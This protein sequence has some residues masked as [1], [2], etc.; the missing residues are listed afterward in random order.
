MDDV[1]IAVIGAGIAGLACARELA[2]ADVAVTVFEKARGL[3]GRLATR[4]EANLVFDHGA[5]YLTAR[6]RAFSRFVEAATHTG[7]VAAWKPRIREDD[8]QW[9]APIGDWYVGR[10]GMSAAVRPLARHVEV[11][12]S[13]GVHELL[14]GQRGWEL[15]TDAGTAPR[16]F[17]AVAV[18]VP[19]PQALTL[20][21]PLGRTFQR[22]SEVRMA[23]CWTVM[24][25]FDEPVDAGAEV[26][27][28]TSGSLTWAAC[29]SSKP[30]RPDGPQCWVAHATPAWSREHLEDDAGDVAQSLWRE[31][32]AA[33]GG[34]L[35]APATLRAHRWRHAFVEQPLGSPCLVDE[36]SAVGACGDW[37]VA[38]RVEAAFDSGRSLAHA[39]LSIVGRASPFLLR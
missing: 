17:D 16:V 18:A 2:R 34:G 19:A 26:Y 27:R 6:G 37:C 10:P 8:R 38:P 21:S 22:V 9:D 30:G 28:W 25:S 33:V 7:T 1:R 3:G 24:M 12:T 4:R 11:L 32:S 35:P 39:L 31:F 5:Q 13:V 15:M 36:E 29:D 14:A 23:P 20:L